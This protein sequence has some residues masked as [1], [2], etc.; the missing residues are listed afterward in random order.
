MRRFGDMED[1][2]QLP[3]LGA[4]ARP[5]PDFLA[6][7]TVG[8]GRAAGEASWVDG[9]LLGTGLVLGAALLDKSFD[10]GAQRNADDKWLTEDTF[11]LVVQ[12][13]GKRRAELQVAVGVSEADVVKLVMESSELARY[14]EGKTPRRV[15]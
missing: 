5:W 2:Y 14:L 3:A 9:L 7:D 10:E 8:M 4:D 6:G 1:D 11:P 12:I 15:V 13:G